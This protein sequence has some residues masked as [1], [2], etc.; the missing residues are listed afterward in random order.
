MGTSICCG[1][2]PEVSIPNVHGFFVGTFWY[3]EVEE[4]VGASSSFEV[5]WRTIVLLTRGDDTLT[6]CT[7]LVRGNVKAEHIHLLLMD[8]THSTRR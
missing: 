7:P 5:P 1:G 3:K 8:K 6:P 2:K 4:E